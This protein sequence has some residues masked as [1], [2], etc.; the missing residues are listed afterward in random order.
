MRNAVRLA[1][2]CRVNLVATVEVR[3]EGRVRNERSPKLQTTEMLRK[4]EAGEQTRLTRVD[5]TSQGIAPEAGGSAE[6]ILRRSPR[7]YPVLQIAADLAAGLGAAL[8]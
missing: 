3:L 5:T 2:C 8:S 6:Q 7:S 1:D 4:V